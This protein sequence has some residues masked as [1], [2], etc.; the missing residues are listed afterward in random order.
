MAMGT[1]RAAFAGLSLEAAT[2]SGNVLQ[3]RGGSTFNQRPIFS[4][5]PS[6]GSN[7][8]SLP[9]QQQSRVG[10]FSQS[11]SAVVDTEFRSGTANKNQRGGYAVPLPEFVTVGS[12]D[13]IASVIHMLPCMIHTLVRFILQNFHSLVSTTLAHSHLLFF[14]CYHL[15]SSSLAS[16]LRSFI[17]CWTHRPVLT[18]LQ[19]IWSA[20]VSLTTGSWTSCLQLWDAIKLRGAV[21]LYCMSGFSAWV[22]PQMTAS[23]PP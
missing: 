22:T 5:G 15:S 9:R 16:F 1:L 13:G 23:A 21:L 8:V 6:R 14:R 2:G 19:L 11:A 3:S 12:C 10:A 18:C 20:P 4:N 7:V 17:A